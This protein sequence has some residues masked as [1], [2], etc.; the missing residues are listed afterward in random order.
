MSFLSQKEIEEFRA[1][2]EKLESA[3]SELNILGEK[4]MDRWEEQ[5]EEWKDTEVGHHW[6][7]IFSEL[8][9]LDLEPPKFPDEE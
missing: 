4:Y 9:D 5:S 6:Q 2:W 7:S 3:V 1:H 8:L